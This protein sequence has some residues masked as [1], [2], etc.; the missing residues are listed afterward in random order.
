MRMMNK[1]KQLFLALFFAFLVSGCAGTGYTKGYKN[2]QNGAFLTAQYGV[3]DHYFKDMVV[4][5]FSYE[6]LYRE[7]CDEISGLLTDSVD[8]EKARVVRF[9]F[10]G[11]E[12][13]EEYLIPSGLQ[14]VR[15]KMESFGEP[16]IFADIAYEFEEGKRYKVAF[17]SRK[18]RDYDEI[19]IYEKTGEGSKKIPQSDIYGVQV[20]DMC[21]DIKADKAI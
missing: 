11:E 7:G 3:E 16:I 12:E 2:I 17:E 6:Q 18:N 19:N 9:A 10:S 1:Y 13:S 4:S 5:V 8:I 20:W 14:V 21:Q 15:L